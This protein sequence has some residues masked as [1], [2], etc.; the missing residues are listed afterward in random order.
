MT[1]K[2]RE[3]I[4]CMNEFCWE[5]C[6]MNAS[7]QEANDYIRRNYELYQLMTMDNW[8]YDYM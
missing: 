4:E 7:V 3:L 8:Q 2:Q 6:D 1:N 5:K